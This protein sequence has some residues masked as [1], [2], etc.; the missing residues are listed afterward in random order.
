MQRNRGPR[1]T[2]YNEPI[3][4]SLDLRAFRQWPGRGNAPAPNGVSPQGEWPGDAPSADNQPPGYGDASAYGD[5]GGY[6]SGYGDTNNQWSYA[7][8]ASPNINPALFPA[9]PVFPV[10]GNVICV[11]IRAGVE[12]QIALRR[13]SNGARIFLFI[14]TLDPLNTCYVAFDQPASTASFAASLVF[15][16]G[17]S[18][19]FMD[20]V[21]Q[22][23]IHVI[24][25]A[26]DTQ[27]IV[28]YCESQF[29]L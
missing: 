8:G 14:Q 10:M 21:P 19:N 22:N 2:R 1:A 29:N 28:L 20:F 4:S 11:P 3:D 12:D 17:A 16:P 23:D 24:A 15:A 18:Y 13:S 5:G 26:A 27:F 6:P 25:S 7:G 9:L